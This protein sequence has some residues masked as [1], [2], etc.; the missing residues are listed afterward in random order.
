MNSGTFILMIFHAT[1]RYFNLCF[2]GQIIDVTP[3]FIQ[4]YVHSFT[5]PFQNVGVNWYWLCQALYRYNKECAIVL[6]ANQFS[7]CRHCNMMDS[8]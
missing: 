1:A 5:A 6:S 7:T 2:T 3:L 4:A 8:Q